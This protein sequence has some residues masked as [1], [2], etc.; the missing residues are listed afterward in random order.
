[1]TAPIVPFAGARH[2]VFL[3]ADQPRAE[4]FAEVDLWLEWLH[5]HNAAEANR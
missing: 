2:D 5:G 1:M 3:S 4:A